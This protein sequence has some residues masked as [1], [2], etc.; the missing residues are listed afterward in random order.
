MIVVVTVAGGKFSWSVALQ[1][2]EQYPL[3][4]NVEGQVI[5]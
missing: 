1:D 3:L 2:D 5:A 4:A